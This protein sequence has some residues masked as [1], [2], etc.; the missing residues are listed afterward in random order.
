[1]VKLALRGR[2]LVAAAVFFRRRI[3]LFGRYWGAGGRLSQPAFR[4]LLSPGDRVL[5]RAGTDALRARHPGR[6]QGARAASSRLVTWSA[7]CIADRQLRTRDRRLPDARGR[8]VD[9]LRARGPGARARSAAA[10][11]RSRDRRRHHLALARTMRRI[12]FR[13]RSRRSRTRRGCSPPAVT[14]RPERLIAAYRRGIFPWYSPGQPVLWWSPD[15][16]AVLFPE[17]FHCSRSLAETL[18]NGGFTPRI[19]RDFAAVI[20]G[21]RRAARGE[22][23]H[24][25]H[26][27]D[28][29][30]L[31]RAAPPRLR[32]QHRGRGAQGRSPAGSTGCAWG[33]CSSVSRCSAA[34][35]TPPRRRSR[36]WWRCAER[37]SIAVIDCQLPSRHLASLGARTIPRS[38][39]QALLAEHV[40]SGGAPLLPP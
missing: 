19:D 23:R 27:R 4:D 13:R 38:R 12:G 20:D 15:P 39:F 21:V 1:M 5:H 17:E 14:C 40:R 30:R 2:A 34:S 6:A 3:T 10:Q 36:T 8:A 33:G 18:R 37:N 9:S 31:P 29:R 28:A 16:R 26:L 25:D 7:H 35:A 24:L 11:R 32:A 22:P